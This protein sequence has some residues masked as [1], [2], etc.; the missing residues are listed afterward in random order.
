MD[1]FEVETLRYHDYI[2]HAKGNAYQEDYY[3]FSTIG[4]A[5]AMFRKL[6]QEADAR[7]PDDPEIVEIYLNDLAVGY[8][9]HCYVSK[10][11]S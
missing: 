11:A 3:T 1:E 7:R 6:W 4:D 2:D 9:I 5:Y 8:T 10:G